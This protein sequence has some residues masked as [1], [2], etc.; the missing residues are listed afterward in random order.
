M[1]TKQE[2]LA[3]EEALQ[4]ANGAISCASCCSDEHNLARPD[5]VELFHR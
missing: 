5:F 3:C 4:L 2:H 1:A